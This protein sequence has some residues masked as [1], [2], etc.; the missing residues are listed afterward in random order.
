MQPATDIT[1][2]DIVAENFRAA[3]V[4][5]KYGLDFCC[6][7]NRR[8][9]DACAE[10]GISPDVIFN[11]LAKIETR[12]DTVPR[13]NAWEPD[14]LIDYILNNHHHYIRVMLPI[15]YLH[16]KKI[17]DVHGERHPELLEVA[18]YF[19]KIGQ[20]LEMHMRKEEHVLFPYIKSLVASR[21]VGMIPAA[22]PFG[23]VR[24][25]IAMME[26]EH[27]TAGD[28]MAM[29]RTLTNN[30]TPPDDACT[31]YRVTFQELEEFEQDLHRHVHLE[32]NILFPKAVA[33]EQIERRS[34]EVAA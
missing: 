32:N 8:V 21:R 30:Y 6:R 24:N 5:Q 1:I 14:F 23:S 12:E 25:P 4:F 33:L 2:R 15:L 20:E 34:A 26:A 19:A 13:F 16:T 7:G 29:I 17:A 3:A 27:Q 31:T 22:P 18:S 10:Q 11:D 28:E 9:T